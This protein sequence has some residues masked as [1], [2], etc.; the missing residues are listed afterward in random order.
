[1]DQELYTEL[2]ANV[3]AYAAAGARHT[4]HVL[5]P[6]GNSF[7]RYRRQLESVTSSPTPSIGAYL[8]EQTI[9]TIFFLAGFETTEPWAFLRRVARTR[10]TKRTRRR[11]TI[12]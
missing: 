6:D 8:F 2:L 3:V 11:I 5:S 12:T 7:L 10:T 9:L 4:P 1:M